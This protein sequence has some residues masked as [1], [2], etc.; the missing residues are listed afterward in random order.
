MIINIVLTI[1]DAAFRTDWI[2]S[3]FALV[4]LIPIL[5]IGAR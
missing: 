1:A 3:I 2:T 4:M 5:S